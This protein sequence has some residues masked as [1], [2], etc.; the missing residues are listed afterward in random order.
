MVCCCSKL[1]IN[2]YLNDPGLVKRYV[3]TKS[4]DTKL[5]SN[6]LTLLLLL[7]LNRIKL[8]NIIF[9]FFT[10]IIIIIIIIIIVIT[11]IMITLMA[12]LV[13][14]SH[15]MPSMNFFKAHSTKSK[16][17]S[18]WPCGT[19]HKKVAKDHNAVCCNVCSQWEHISCNKIT[20]YTYSKLQKEQAPW[21][22]KNV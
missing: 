3:R 12:L 13:Y 1:C 19:Y 10:F 9:I 6:I 8:I 15:L 22:C 17:N 2:C 4:F 14:T 18:P 5:L 11:I 16:M 7:G 21:Y 20:R